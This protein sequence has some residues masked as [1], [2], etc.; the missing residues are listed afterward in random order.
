MHY[1]KLLND[2]LTPLKNKEINILGYDDSNTTG[3]LIGFDKF[4]IWISDT[5]R[6]KHLIFDLENVDSITS[7]YNLKIEDNREPIG[8]NL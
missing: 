8:E 3:I 5:G 2:F 1:S 4:S 6:S 7:G